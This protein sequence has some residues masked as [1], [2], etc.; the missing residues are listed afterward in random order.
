[1]GGGA[2]V[3]GRK[4]TLLSVPWPRNPRW[5]EKGVITYNPDSSPGAAASVPLTDTVALATLAVAL[6]VGAAMAD[7]AAAAVK[8]TMRWVQ[9]KKVGIYILRELATYT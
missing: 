2:G 5:P 8:S 1:M 9:R 4:A 6:A 7:K 3:N